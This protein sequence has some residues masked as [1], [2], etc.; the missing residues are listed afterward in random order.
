[1]RKQQRSEVY[2]KQCKTFKKRHTMITSDLSPFRFGYQLKDDADELSD[3]DAGGAEPNEANNPAASR[4]DDDYF[5]GAFESFAAGFQPTPEESKN[6]PATN[7][8]G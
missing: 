1:M 6:A 8:F 3:E 5:T 2:R 7:A 4:S